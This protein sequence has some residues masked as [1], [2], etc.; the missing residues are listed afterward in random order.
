MSTVITPKR[1]SKET[2]VPFVPGDPGVVVQRTACHG[3]LMLATLEPTTR[4]ASLR[5]Y[6]WEP[7]YPRSPRSAIQPSDQRYA[8]APPV[9]VVVLYP[10][11][12]PPSLIPLP[13]DMLPPG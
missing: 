1:A 12:W 10:T 4:P 13:V 7:P 6:A 9:S 11:T 2:P 8:W 3:P 5:S